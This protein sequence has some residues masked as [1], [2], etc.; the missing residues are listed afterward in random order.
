MFNWNLVYS[1][2]G[3]VHYH[4]LVGA[5]SSPHGKE[6]SNIPP[7]IHHPLTESTN[8]GKAPKRPVPHS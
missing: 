8:E 1:F 3:I 7:S 5:S 6:S 2:R 4:C